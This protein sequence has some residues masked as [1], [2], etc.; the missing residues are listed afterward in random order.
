MLRNIICVLLVS[1]SVVS[2]TKFNKPHSNELCESYLHRVRTILSNKYANID[3]KDFIFSKPTPIYISGS[4]VKCELDV[5]VAG[6][7]GYQKIV[8]FISKD[9]FEVMEGDE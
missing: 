4:D 6:Y 5:S 2:C 9:V 7:D 8:Y 1:A 3:K